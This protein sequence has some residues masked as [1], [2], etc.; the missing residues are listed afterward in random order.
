MGALD[1]ENTS[2]NDVDPQDFTVK[3]F[4]LHPEFRQPQKYHDIAIIELNR[5]VRRNKYVNI[6]C[7]DNEMIHTNDE[8]IIAGW[9][10]T[11]FAGSSSGQLLKASLNV[12]DYQTCSSFYK[13][14]PKL[15]PNGI[16]DDWMICAG[17]KSDTCNVSNRCSFIF[18][19]NFQRF[20]TF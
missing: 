20:M 8:L 4:V 12:V 3:R 14:E 7:L 1:I 11:E 9:G 16:V 13:G 10:Q 2:S 5:P 17:G 15:L 6:A 19:Q 18:F